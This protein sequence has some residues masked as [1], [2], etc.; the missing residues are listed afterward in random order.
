MG[1]GR[2]GLWL[3]SGSGLGRGVM[4]GG[5]CV[6]GGRRRRRRG[7]GRR[8]VAAVSDVRPTRS[9]FAH[10][11]VTGEKFE[12]ALRHVQLALRVTAGALVDTRRDGGLAVVFDFHLLAAASAIELHEVHRDK[13]VAVLVVFAG[14]GVGAGVGGVPGHASVEGFALR[15]A[16]ETA[17]TTA[18]VTAR[19]VRAGHGTSDGGE[20]GEL[21]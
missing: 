15:E 7:W 10:A 4:G 1:G 13:P 16:V 5:R 8:R 21:A 6:S 3:G 14:A 20:E 9:K 2:R 19:G 11:Q 17:E 18:V 12:E